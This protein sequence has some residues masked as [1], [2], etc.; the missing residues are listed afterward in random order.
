MLKPEHLAAWY[1]RL[2]GFFT[3]NNFVLHPSRRGAKRTDADILGVRFPFRAEFPDAPGGD[4]H[5]FARV[6]DSPYFVIVEVKR[7]RCELN[8]PWTDSSKQNIHQV[9][10]DL[11]PFPSEKV[12]AVAD[13]LYSDGIYNDPDLYCSLLCVGDGLS[14]ELAASYPRVPQRTWDQVLAFLFERFDTYH[15]RKADHDS[16]DDVGQ[17]VWN[18]WDGKA[19]HDF[20]VEAKKQFG[21]RE[22][23]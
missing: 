12:P 2:N 7:G 23:A 22:T 16:W 13:S 19:K 18:C 1:F 11:G 10:L 20:M 9:L 14:T 6:V 4:E 3:I 5:E 8:G 15:R 17:S 21:L